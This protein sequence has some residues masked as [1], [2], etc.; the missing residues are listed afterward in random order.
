MLF[1]YI[2]THWTSECTDLITKIV[3]VELKFYVSVKQ[4]Q[5][6]G[7]FIKTYDKHNMFPFYL[8]VGKLREVWNLLDIVN[9]PNI[10]IG[11]V[12]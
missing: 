6:K 5:M 4:L 10:C 2:N 1:G 7:S 9:I 8:I 3:I 11:H 12:Q